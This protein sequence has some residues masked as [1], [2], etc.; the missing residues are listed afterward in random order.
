M[1]A[2]RSSLSRDTIQSIAL[3]AFERLIVVFLFGR[4]AFKMLAAPGSEVDFVT[5]LILLSEI[6]PV[7]FI[8]S[9]RRSDAVSR[10]PSDWLLGIS[11]AIIP[12]LVS[13]T[14][15]GSLAP[16][17]VCA[18]IMLAGLYLQI[19]AKVSLGQSFGLVAANR[20]VKVVGP[21]RFVRHPMYAGYMI[22]HVGF[23]LAFPSLWNAALYSAEFA[24]QVARLLREEHFLG[25]DQAY[26]AYAARVR[27]RLL[28]AIF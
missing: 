17:G 22:A 9:R 12:L 14:G 6:L 24:I 1:D 25:Q 3:D 8:L 10:K 20:G 21:Y 11:G 5:V 28:P 13:P 26:R 23:L 4:F 18:V 19:S 16:H 7:I 15:P 27:Y 2:P